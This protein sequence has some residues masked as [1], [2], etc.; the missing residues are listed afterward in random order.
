MVSMVKINLIRKEKAMKKEKI[1][2]VKEAKV[3]ISYSPVLMDDRTFDLAWY[4]R[5]K[6]KKEGRF[7]GLFEGNPDPCK[8]SYKGREA[9]FTAGQIRPVGK[10]GSESDFIRLCLIRLNVTSPDPVSRGKIRVALVNAGY[11]ASIQDAERRLKTYEKSPYNNLSLSNGDSRLRA[12]LTGQKDVDF[13][14][15][16]TPCFDLR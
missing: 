10:T 7:A 2:V 11:K 16:P 3:G 13:S 12:I 14:V 4:S 6:E 8:P 9:T 5:S 1:V 15:L